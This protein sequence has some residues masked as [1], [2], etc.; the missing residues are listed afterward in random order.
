MQDLEK[1]R[2]ERNL[3]ISPHMAWQYAGGGGD[4]VMMKPSEMPV[5]CVTGIVEAMG[6]Q[7][8]RKMACTGGKAAAANPRTPDAKQGVFVPRRAAE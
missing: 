5:G 6:A 8:P 2:I 1:Q 4:G 7:A 3:H